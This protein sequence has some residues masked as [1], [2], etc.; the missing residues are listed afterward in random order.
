MALSLQKGQRISL[1][2]QGGEK[3]LNFCIGLNWGAI[4]EKGFFGGVKTVAVDLDASCG[5]FDGA[6]KLVDVVFFGNLRSKD[7]SIAHSGDDV[8]G[9]TGGDDG[10]DNE[11]ITLDLSRV[12]ANTQQIVFILNSFRGHDF[13]DIPHAALRIYEGTPDRV[14]NVV[15]TYNIANDPKF[16]G[17]VSMIMGKL[18]RHQ[19]SWKFAAIGEPTRDKKLD[20][21][22][23]TVARQY[24]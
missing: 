9:D 1:E 15:A 20:E 11:I 17:F 10:L 18:Y 23:G 6:N 13:G 21:S 19:G 16:K 4:Q 24:L 5:L 7:G 2:K 8:T 12:D 14:E 3:L 22:L